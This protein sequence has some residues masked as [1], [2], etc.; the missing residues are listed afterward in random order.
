[1]G[2]APPLTPLEPRFLMTLI[3]LLVR[4]FGFSYSVLFY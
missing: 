3:F 2:G 1:M 4:E